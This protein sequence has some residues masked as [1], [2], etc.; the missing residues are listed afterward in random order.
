MKST[1]CNTTNYTMASSLHCVL[2]LR[3]AHCPQSP[4]FKCPQSVLNMGDTVDVHVISSSW[5][6]RME[7]Q[8]TIVNWL[9]RWCRMFIIPDDWTLHKKDSVNC[10][11][12]TFEVQ[13]CCIYHLLYVLIHCIPS[14]E[15]SVC[16]VL[17]SQY[18][19]V[20][21]LHSISRITFLMWNLYFLWCWNWIGVHSALVRINE[22]LLE[23][24][25]AAPV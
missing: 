13:W 5:L 16:F 15:F 2:L 12:C 10:V 4:V 24:K 14:T 18:T 21:S 20:A 17:S 19:A 6:G 25:V 7:S 8:D 22:E 9:R 1:N 3:F 11:T 23:R